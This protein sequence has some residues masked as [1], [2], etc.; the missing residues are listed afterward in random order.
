MI[1]SAKNNF[2]GSQ[3]QNFTTVSIHIRLTDFEGH[4]KGLWNLTYAPPAYFS[5]AMQYFTDRYEVIN[6]L[7]ILLLLLLS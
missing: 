1:Q 7:L 6:I 5:N 3:L 2:S 4:L